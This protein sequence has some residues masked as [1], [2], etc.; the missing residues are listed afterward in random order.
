MSEAIRQKVE[1][2]L[3]CDWCNEEIKHYGL[4]RHSLTTTWPTFDEASTGGLLSDFKSLWA[5]WI[6]RPTHH[7][8]TSCADSILRKALATKQ[9]KEK[10]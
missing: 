9:D 2:Y 8:H 1:K 10:L 4:N 3:V 5:N 6:R 7:F